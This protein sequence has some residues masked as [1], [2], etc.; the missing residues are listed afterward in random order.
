MMPRSQLRMFDTETADVLPEAR[1]VLVPER[2]TFFV[3][4]SDGPADG[5]AVMLLHGLGA[6]ADLTW[7][8]TMP[9]LSS[10]FRV[11]APDLRGHGQTAT[12]D[13]FTLEDAADDV[14]AL[15]DALSLNHCIVVGYSM[16]G[17]IAQLVCK[18]YPE[19]VGG[20]V[21]C[22][23][24][25]SFVGT[26]RERALLAAVRPVR[27]ASRA[28]ADEVVKAAARRIAHHVVGER[29]GIGL[30][31]HVRILDVGQVLEAVCSLGDFRS[32]GWIGAIDVPSAVLVHLRDRRVPAS[33]QFELAHA[34]PGAIAH[35]I[36]SDHFAAVKKPD[37]FVSTLVNAV[38]DVHRRVMMTQNV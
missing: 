14:A 21:L 8:T 38:Q 17:A 15:A 2:G 36:D 16:G 27:V 34:L 28:V 24:S 32:D 4:V 30:D 13:R 11:V 26:W 33:R 10:A 29:A 22:A 1:V 37:A 5:P 9:A 18:R 19:K 3:R 31:D 6:T 7:S 23:T 20:L 35:P 25:R 12:L